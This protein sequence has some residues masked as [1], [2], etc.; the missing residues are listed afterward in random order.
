MS[1]NE[2]F[3]MLYHTSLRN[4]GLFLTI[5]LGLQGY[6]LRVHTPL[7]KIVVYACHLLFLGISIYINYLLIDLTTKEKKK[8]NLDTRWLY[9]SYATISFLSILMIFNLY[10][11]KN[12]I[13]NYFN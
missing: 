7:K 10:S 1:D 9:I 2:K 3:L 5:A 11:F 6:S 4:V 13:V 12:K 8:N